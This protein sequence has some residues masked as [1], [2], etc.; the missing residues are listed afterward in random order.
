MVLQK[1]RA[2]IEQLLNSLPA[3]TVGGGISNGGGIA[4]G[5]LTASMP[6]FSCSGCQQ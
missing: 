4:P 3:G 5:T 2:D 6:I 1:Q